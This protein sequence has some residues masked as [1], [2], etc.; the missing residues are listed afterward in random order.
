MRRGLK[1]SLLFSVLLGLAP[2]I[3]CGGSPGGT[4]PPAVHLPPPVLP[5][6]PRSGSFRELAVAGGGPDRLGSSVAGL[7]I[8]GDGYSDVIIGAPQWDSETCAPTLDGGQGYA[9]VIFGGPGM[10]SVPDLVLHGPG[11][12]FGTV[13]APAG[14]LNGDGYPDLAV[15]APQTEENDLCLDAAP[16]TAAVSIF[17]GRPGTEWGPTATP[18]LVITAEQANDRFGAAIGP[19][20]SGRLA[21]GAPYYSAFAPGRHGRVYVIDGARLGTPSSPVPIWT[22]GPATVSGPGSAELFGSALTT[23]DLDGDR[24]DELVIGAPGHDSLSG[25]IYMIPL[26]DLISGSAAVP[27]APL[28]VGQAPKGWFGGS[29][30]VG[31]FNG[32]SYADLAVGAYH[33]D[34]NG[35][36]G[37]DRGTV[38]IYLGPLRRNLGFLMLSGS[39]DGGQFGFSLATVGDATGFGHDDLLI[40]SPVLNGTGAVFLYEGGSWDQ[41][42][43]TFS[44]GGAGDVFGYSVAGVGDINGDGLTDLGIGARFAGDSSVYSGKGYIEY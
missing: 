15:G 30:A 35:V 1:Y 8:N 20:G 34:T 38:S 36:P 13:V 6:D 24:T 17:Y 44:G 4:D 16:T 42:L 27:T 14:D 18:D 33:A 9:V 5:V 23:G 39:Q 40:G 21:I 19:A 31:D 3:G 29:L 12:R 41:P 7:D 37:S 11:P 2:L 10:D 28:F 25:A 26:R 43:R 22:L 32:D